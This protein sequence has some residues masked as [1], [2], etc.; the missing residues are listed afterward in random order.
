MASTI[1]VLKFH[2]PEGAE[3]GLAIAVDLQKQH[4]LEIQD[5]ATVTWPEGKKKPKTVHGLDACGGAWYGAFWGMLIG[6]IFFAPF[7]GAAWGAAM[8]ALSAKFADYGVGKDFI[9]NVR[10][11]VTEGSSALFLLV[12]QVTTDRVVEAFKSAPDFEVI[13]TNLSED[14]EEK[15]KEAFAH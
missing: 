10:G 3:Q 6:C 9:E 2:S 4:L 15:L 14:Q 7:L 11:K 8:G 5:V 12:G 1:V 13:S